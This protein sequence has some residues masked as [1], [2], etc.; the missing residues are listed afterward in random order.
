VL[1][2]PLAIDRRLREVAHSRAR[3]RRALR[4]GTAAEHAFE[5]VGSRVDEELLDELRSAGEGDPLGPALFRWAYLL[6]EDHELVELDQSLA[7]AWHE[8]RHAF[9]QPLQGSFTLSELRGRALAERGDGR[10]LFLSAFLERAHGAGELAL[11]RWERRAE[12][13][14]RSKLPSLD[15][16]EGVAAPHLELPEALLGA[17]AE[18]FAELEVKR[19]SELVELGLGRDSAANWPV[20]LTLRSLATLLDEPAWF[21]HVT[22]ELEPLPPPLGAASFLRGL[23]EL[24]RALRETFVSP[25]LPFVLA[26]DPLELETAIWGALFALLPFG[27]SFATRKLE[28]ARARLADH[29]RSLARVLVIAARAASLRARLRGPALVGVTTARK[30]YPELAERTFGIELPARVAGALFCPER[31]SPQQALA[32]VL[33]AELDTRL[34]EAHDEDWYRNPR[35]VAELREG[36]ARAPETGFAPERIGAGLRALARRLSV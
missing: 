24:G 22:L 7:R 10:E 3:F 16:L 35:A 15:E 18:A 13:A 2:N 25:G 21:R 23:R 11:R 17:T 30:L 28:V 33:A 5:S 20:H 32:L 19:A 31:N 14:A 1:E 29:R 6:R 26:H 4:S 9:D 34:T 8:E 27:E 36:A 12:H